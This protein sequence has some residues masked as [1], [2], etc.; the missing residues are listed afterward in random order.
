VLVIT[1]DPPA[2]AQCISI[3]SEFWES[4]PLAGVVFRL[5]NIP[6]LFVGGLVSN[7]LYSKLE[8]LLGIQVGGAKVI[9]L[10]VFK[11]RLGL[12]V[13]DGPFDVGR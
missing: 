5:A 13:K 4:R 7:K 9:A 11:T 10:V 2:N 6:V 1:R 3:D 8:R 12:V